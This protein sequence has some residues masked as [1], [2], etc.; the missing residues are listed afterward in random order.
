VT[1]AVT[2]ATGFVGQALLDE[3]ARTG[4]EVRALTRREQP[5]RKRVEWVAGDLANHKA[6]AKLTKGA[7]AVIHIA[8]VVNAPNPAGFEEGNVAGT[9]AVVEAAVKRGVPRFVHISS[10]AAREPK[11]SAYGASKKRAEKVVKASGLDWTI[12]RPPAIF[13]PRDT[14]MFDLFRAAK[15][16]IVPIP[17]DGR[18]S[19]IHVADLA[20]LLLALLPGGEDVTHQAFEPDDG[21]AGGWS[22]RELA[23]AI[24]WAV[25]RRPFVPRL[26]RPMLMRAAALD[27]LIRKGK[28][29]LTPDRVSYMCHP[30]WVAAK[31]KRPPAGRWTPG[32][33]TREG[34]RATA[35]WY[36]ENKWL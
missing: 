32:I 10:L 34:L 19:L 25:N 5:P 8:G 2:G 31:G 17:E 30:D 6:L 27:G 24:G 21:H 14:E 3:A 4:L 7:E 28:A 11:L 1:I 22:H 15:W 23:R 36:R 20:R 29:K 18:A 13:G 35:A 26:S 33:D 9:L 16:G 12:V